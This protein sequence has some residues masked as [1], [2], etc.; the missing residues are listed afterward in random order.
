MTSGRRG[1]RRRSSQ[2]RHRAPVSGHLPGRHAPA[3]RSTPSSHASASPGC[4]QARGGD[5]GW[6]RPAIADDPGPRRPRAVLARAAACRSGMERRPARHARRCVRL[7]RGRDARASS[8]TFSFDLREFGTDRERADAAAAASAC[9]ICACASP[10][11]PTSLVVDD[12]SSTSRS[13]ASS[14]AGRSRACASTAACSS[15]IASLRERDVAAV[16]GARARR[17]RRGRVGVLDLAPARDPARPTW[18]RRF[19]TSRS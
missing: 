17:D 5:R 4:R 8:A 1:M 19:P 3:S 18:A 2:D 9:A 6:W 13:P 10:H 7:A 16:G 14:I 15:S 11:R 12:G